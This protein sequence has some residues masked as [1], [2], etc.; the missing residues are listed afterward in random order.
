MRELFGALI[1]PCGSQFS[2]HGSPTGCGVVSIAMAKHI[3][4]LFHLI[5]SATTISLVALDAWMGRT[6]LLTRYTRENGF[7]EIASSILLFCAGLYLLYVSRKLLPAGLRLAVRVLAV[8]FIVGALEEISWGQHLLGFETGDFFANNRQQETN[9]HNFLPPWLFGLMVNLGFYVIF[10]YIPICAH[11]FEEHLANTRQSLLE[12]L[13]PLLPS[14]H[15]LLV[16]CFGFALQKYFILETL[17]DTAALV[18]ALVLVGIVVLRKPRALLVLHLLFILAA[19]GFFMLSNSAFSYENV[20]YEIR[21]LI[22]IY[23]MIYWVLRSLHTWQTS[24]HP[25]PLISKSDVV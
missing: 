8:L 9:L 1:D 11:L 23:A 18:I 19:T 7:F 22:F 4:Y 14:V 20:Q 16:F 21:E 2:R 24:T 17:S 6:G 15:L 10:V 3:F 12:V 25:Q 5:I 13:T